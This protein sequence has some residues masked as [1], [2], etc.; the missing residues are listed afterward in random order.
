MKG[1]HQYNLIE[2]GGPSLSSSNIHR[3][4]PNYRSPNMQNPPRPSKEMID[5]S[6]RI[7][8]TRSPTKPNPVQP[9]RPL[10]RGENDSGYSEMEFSNVSNASRHG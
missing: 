8:Q 7:P 6:H 5:S 10:Y 2:L 4:D 3:R 1:Q 9:S